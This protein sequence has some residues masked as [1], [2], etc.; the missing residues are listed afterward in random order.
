M[1][2][3]KQRTFSEYVRLNP[4][5]LTPAQLTKLSSEAD[6]E[7]GRRVVSDEYLDFRLWARQ[8][9]SRVETFFKH[10]EPKLRKYSGKILEVGCGPRALLALRLR[11]VGHE[12]EAMD[13]Q[14]GDTL[15]R[16]RDGFYRQAL[17]MKSDIS[18]YDCVVALEPCDA[19]EIIIQ[20]CVAEQK[21]YAI[22]PCGTPHARLD[23]QIPRTAESWWMH[24]VSLDKRIHLEPLSVAGY[25]LPVLSCL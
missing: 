17:S 23:G 1:E 4:N 11:S 25:L 15:L 10:I 8:Q 18:Q 7:L 2:P 3:D 19:A 12:V 20:L 14:I 22:V 9:P 13:P 24:L 16:S 5:E 6:Q 21:P